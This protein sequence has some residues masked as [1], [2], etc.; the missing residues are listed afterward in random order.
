MKKKIYIAVTLILG[1]LI[2]GAAV[3]HL[4]MSTKIKSPVAAEPEVIHHVRKVPRKSID[5]PDN[6]KLIASLHAKIAKL[7]ADRA[8]SHI[9]SSQ[10][11]LKTAENPKDERRREGWQARME[12]MKTEEPEKYAEMEQRRAEFKVR[13]EERKLNKQEFLESVDTATMS[14]VQREN[15]DRLVALTERVN[16]IT[17]MMISGETENRRELRHEMF[18]SYNELRELNNNERVYLL[19]ETARAVG[20]KGAAADLFTA[21]L[22]DIIQNTTMQ[23]PGPTPGGGRGRGGM[24]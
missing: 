7:E 21:H 12:R 9:E 19:E 11:E 13:M 23:M 18:Q 15:H 1:G 24:Q 10:T 4:R 16:E 22:E 5:S 8:N 3:E 6:N 2:V 17:E 14:A 20:Y